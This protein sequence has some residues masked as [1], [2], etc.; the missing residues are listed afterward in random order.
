MVARAAN[1]LWDTMI[2][3]EIFDQNCENILLYLIS[4]KLRG[5]LFLQISSTEGSCHNESAGPV[6]IVLKNYL[7]T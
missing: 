7:I 2:I 6:A 1:I 4:R 5:F 3:Y